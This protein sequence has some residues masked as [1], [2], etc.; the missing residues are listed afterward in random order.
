[1]FESAADYFSFQDLRLIKTA[2]GFLV[3]SPPSFS[4]SLVLSDSDWKRLSQLFRTL[5]ESSPK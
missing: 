5:E 4:K 2:L 3:T 1:M